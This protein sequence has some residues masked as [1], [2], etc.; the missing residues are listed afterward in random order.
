LAAFLDVW[1]GH[2]VHR[3]DCLAAGNRNTSDVWSHTG[4]TLI[5]SRFRM[6]VIGR[7]LAAATTWSNAAA[8]LL[9]VWF[10]CKDRLLQP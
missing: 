6:M 2:L 10:G 9:E 1:F 7:R 8:A 5:G 4:F 3:A